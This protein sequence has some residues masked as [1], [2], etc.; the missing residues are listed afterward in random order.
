[1]TKNISDKTIHDWDWKNRKK[2]WILIKIIHDCDWKNRKKIVFL[3]NLK[4]R[5]KNFTLQNDSLNFFTCIIDSNTM[6]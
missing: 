4:I 3:P 1:M 6:Q 2:I 5:A